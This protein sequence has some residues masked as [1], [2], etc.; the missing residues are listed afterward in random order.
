MLGSKASCCSV[1]LVAGLI[2]ISSIGI[3]VVL[4]PGLDMAEHLLVLLIDTC[5][6]SYAL[7]LSRMRTCVNQP[8]LTFLI[9]CIFPF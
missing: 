1:G 4:G 6:C 7:H 2:C 3:S 8:K 9:A 5:I